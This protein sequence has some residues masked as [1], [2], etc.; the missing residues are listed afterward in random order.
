MKHRIQVGNLNCLCSMADVARGITYILYPMD[1]LGDWI[2][3]AAKKYG[4]AIVVITG[5]EWED[6]FSPWPAE[7][8]PK[9]SPDFKG[10][11][12]QFLQTLRKEVIPQVE[13]ILCVGTPTERTLVGV[14]MSGPFAMWQWMLC[15]TFANIASLSG[16]FWYEGFIEWMRA[17]N[18]PAKSGV[19]FF[20]LGDRE[21]KSKVKAFDSVGVNT[22]E[23]V[24]ML[25]SK[26]IRTIFE[27]VPGDHY[28][29]P[30]PRLDRAMEAL[31]G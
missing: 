8:V 10:Q 29:N 12:P 27:S 25:R 11:S 18:I 17:N 24:E 21:S 28:S 22:A 5:M 1:M 23:I 20:L 4:T 15:D 9:G 13:K 16:S 7:G 6:V 30:I 2:E 31:F 3:T 14:S 19:G 26:G